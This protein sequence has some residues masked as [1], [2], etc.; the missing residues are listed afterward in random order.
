MIVL[1]KII[2]KLDSSKFW[3]IG[4]VLVVFGIDIASKQFVRLNNIFTSGHFVDI[5]F[6]QNTGSLFSL[7]HSVSWSNILFIVISLIALFVI[8]Y[9]V[10]VKNECSLFFPLALLTSGILGNVFD[11][12]AYDGVIDWINF[13]FWPIFNIADSAII[14]GVIIAIVIL[15]KDEFIQKK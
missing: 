11:R 5:T 15:V 6:T 12:I 14:C 13:H 1:K 4:I 10:F 9:A 3:F 8:L 2:P 7:L